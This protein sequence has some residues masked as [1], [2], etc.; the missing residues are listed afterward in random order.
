MKHKKYA[1]IIMFISSLLIVG[2]AHAQEV[3]T[4]GLSTE[5]ILNVKRWCAGVKTTSSTPTPK[6]R[7][8]ESHYASEQF[9]LFCHFSVL[10][11][12]TQRQSSHGA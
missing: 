7:F 2:S 9:L 3:D 10:I 8:L 11:P 12:T 4:S 5:S 1:A 6:H